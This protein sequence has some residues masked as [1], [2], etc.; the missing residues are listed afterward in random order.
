MDKYEDYIFASMACTKEIFEPGFG[1]QNGSMEFFQHFYVNL[2]RIL[3][4]YRDFGGNW[5]NFIFSY[6]FLMEKWA[7]SH[8]QNPGKL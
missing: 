6:V 7:Y 5:E 4:R 3:Y 1:V 8:G 2:R